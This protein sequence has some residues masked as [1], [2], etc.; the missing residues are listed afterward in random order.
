[1]KFIDNHTAFPCIHLENTKTKDKFSKSK[2][3]N[4]KNYKTAPHKTQQMTSYENRHQ[5]F[6]CSLQE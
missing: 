1:M 5:L 2:G 6:K 4:E 3:T